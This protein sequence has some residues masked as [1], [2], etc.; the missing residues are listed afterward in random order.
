MNVVKQLAAQNRLRTTTY[1]SNLFQLLAALPRDG[2]GARVAPEKW[3]TYGATTGE[4]AMRHHYE[5]THV[6]LTPVCRW[7]DDDDVCTLA[8]G[9]R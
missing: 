4:A 5:V 8:C 2:V 1:P 9:M 6:R 7:D 3:L